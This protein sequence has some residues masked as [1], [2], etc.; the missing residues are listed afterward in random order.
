MYD[1]LRCIKVFDPCFRVPTR[2]KIKE[3]CIPD[4]KLQVVEKIKQKLNKIR[5]PNVSLDGWSDA[6]MKPFMGYMVQGIDDEWQ[7]QNLFV[8]FSHFKGKHTS[9]NIKT[10]Y[11]K[12][13]SEFELE[14]KVFKIITD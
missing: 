10:H 14:S 1:L 11:D 6:C 2:Y 12:V 4:N 5:F 7:M 3:T 9:E 8:K 13:C